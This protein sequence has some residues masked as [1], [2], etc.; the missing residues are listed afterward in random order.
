[1]NSRKSFAIAR[2]SKYS[3]FKNNS[4]FTSCGTIIKLQQRTMASSSTPKNES[5]SAKNRL[6]HE[7]SPY[8]LQHQSNPVN[9]YPW[10][11]EAFELA[12]SSNKPIFLSVGY[13]T[14]H[15]C[16]VMERESFQDNLIAKVMNEK[17][18]NIKMDREERPDVDKIYMTFV[19]AISGSGGWPMSVWM[20]PNLRPFY[21]GT[22]YP[23][24]D[25]YYGRPGFRS[26]LETISDQWVEDQEKCENSATKI[27]DVLNRAANLPT[28]E[29]ITNGQPAASRCLQQLTRSYEPSFGGFSEH[30]KFPQPV[31]LHFLMDWAMKNPN[32]PTRFSV[33]KMVETTLK[34]MA[35]GGI[36]DH[37]G[38]GFARYST[39]KKWFVPHF[40]KMLY[41][42]AQLAVAYSNAYLLTKDE[43]Y[44][45]IVR[46]ILSYVGRDLTHPEE[47]GIYSAEDA[48]SK[49]SFDSVEK[50][51]GAFYVFTDSEIEEILGKNKQLS[52]GKARV[53]DV[54]RIRYG[55]KPN[56]NVDP[57]S[58]PHDELKQQ[59]VLF[60]AMTIPNIAKKF[61]VSEAEISNVLDEAKTVLFNY[62]NINRPRPGLDTKFVTSWNGL[63]ITGYAKAGMALQSQEYID[64]GVKAMEF[65][66]KYV[67]TTDKNG[68][69][70]LLR[71]CYRDEQ[72]QG[73]CN[74]QTPIFGCVDDFANLLQQRQDELFWDDAV[75]GYF[76]SRAGDE[77]VIIRM[78]DDD[79]G[80]EPSSN[81]TSV[82]N[83]IR[84]NSFLQDASYSSK[85]EKLFKQFSDRISK[86]P[87]TLPVMTS[88]LTTNTKGAHT[89]VYNADDASTKESIRKQLL[90]L[91]TA[92]IG[93][94]SKNHEEIS[95]LLP[96][97]K[98]SLT[99]DI[100]GRKFCIFS[101]GQDSPNETISSLDELDKLWV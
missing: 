77:S 40:E 42:Q 48:D 36:H 41:D 43:F 25:R 79:D 33:I 47:N 95:Q 99:K 9:W 54:F 94:E 20:T 71:S 64:R 101:K 6:Q 81:S 13:S 89:I 68:K 46:D 80:A 44:T 50:K 31:N 29:T 27:L 56:G 7:K 58:D 63:M 45:T 73:V 15:W 21:G 23:P 12:K 38:Q 93:L 35:K 70:D 67:F 17:F 75:G 2:F 39:D 98:I 10:S 87:I 69:F 59:N 100:T 78:K 61:D 82:I 83:L 53:A 96:Y 57:L 30:P 28:G 86:V 85:I 18:I 51:E 52:N 1:M 72:N 19:Q 74:L 32:D 3:N 4:L 84:L 37:I 34:E 5:K 60:E 22:Y 62:R 11:N 92:L 8:L 91:G 49:F 66:V 26:I 76:T 65:L 90:P 97:A 16:H 14:C 55:I 88:A 24:D